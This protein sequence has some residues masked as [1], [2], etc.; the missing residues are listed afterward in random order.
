[1]EWLVKPDGRH[2]I[3]QELDDITDGVKHLYALALEIEKS[4]LVRRLLGLPVDPATTESKTPIGNGIAAEDDGGALQRALAA[5]PVGATGLLERG[6]NWMTGNKSVQSASMKAL[7]TTAMDSLIA[8]GWQ[9]GDAA[10]IIGNLQQ[11]S[12]L[13]PQAGVNTLT[14]HL[15]AH[16]GIAQWDSDRQKAIAEHFGKRVENMTLQE[17]MDAVHWEL[18]E[19]RYKT[20]GDQLRSG[21]H[22]ATDAA[23]TIDHSYEIPANPGTAA[24][25]NE[26][27]NRARN[28]MAVIAD[29]GQGTATSPTSPAIPSYSS[30]AHSQSDRRDKLTVEVIHT[31]PPVDT[32]MRVTHSDPSQVDIAAPKV[33]GAMP[34]AGTPRNVARDGY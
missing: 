17:Q 22:R 33:M 4:P 27:A 1:M 28:A 23:V 32:S 25:A 30:P 26:D 10:G 2:W 12:S 14:G 13:N 9:P 31:N 11:E 29:Y 19:G 24:L 21:S 3:R 8:K 20:V 6:W 15:A 7:S 34:G 18:T 5:A 16:V